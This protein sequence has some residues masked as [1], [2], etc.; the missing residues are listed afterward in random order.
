[1]CQGFGMK[2]IPVPVRERILYLY[3]QGRSTRDIA[4]SL[5]YCVAAVRRVRQH[6]KARRTLVPQTHRCGR[7]TLLDRTPPPT[8]ASAPD[9]TT[10]CDAGR[11]GGAI[12]TPHLDDGSVAGPVGLEL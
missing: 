8:A 1:M 7:K 9:P 11:I 5:G 10:R 4:A 2:A 6:F 3:D 12:Q